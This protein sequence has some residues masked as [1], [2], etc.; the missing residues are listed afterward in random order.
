[1]SLH[2]EGGCAWAAGFRE[3]LLCCVASGRRC[4][5]LCRPEPHSPTSRAAVT[6]SAHSLPDTQ[7]TPAQRTPLVAMT[8][9]IT[10]IVPWPV[11]IGSTDPKA[12]QGGE[13]TFQSV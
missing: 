12:C 5:S 3:A 8:A 11:G 10:L 9:I 4:T 6:G 13:A 1:M 2:C 7:K